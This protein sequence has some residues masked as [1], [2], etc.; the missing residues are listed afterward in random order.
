MKQAPSPRPLR[1]NNKLSSLEKPR[2]PYIMRSVKYGW[3]ALKKIPVTMKALY[4]DNLHVLL[5][6]FAGYRELPLI[7]KSES[8]GR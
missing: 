2:H 1:R 3:D 7:S 4:D 8:K 5:C 6:R